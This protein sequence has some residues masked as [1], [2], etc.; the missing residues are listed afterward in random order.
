MKTPQG[1]MNMNLVESRVVVKFGGADLSTGENIRKAA[2]MVI[3]AG[4]REIVVVVS[5]MGKSTDSLIE[6][7]SQVGEI[8]DK[9]YAEIVS[10]GERTSARLFCA[11]L[12]IK[13]APAL[14]LE[15]S[16]AEWPIVTDSNYREATL[17]LEE[18]CRRTQRFLEPV[19]CKR[20][21]SFVAF[22]AATSLE[23]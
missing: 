10:M 2:E 18:T 19:L 16:M 20:S 8:S 3:N 1:G 23:T 21:R 13:G 11:A 14:F 7:V 9:E 4:Y 5:A 17:D 15:P 12:H 6:T 22:W